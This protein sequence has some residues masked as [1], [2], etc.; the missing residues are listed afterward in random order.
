M[1]KYIATSQFQKLEYIQK[2]GNRHSKIQKE[3]AMKK[4]LQRI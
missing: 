4:W 2:F 3:T 1:R